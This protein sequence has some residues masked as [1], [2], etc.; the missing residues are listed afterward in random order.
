M[1]R[2]QPP[3]KDTPPAKT[4]ATDQP[5]PLAQVK[6]FVLQVG[7]SMYI[8]APELK[9][10]E[11][12]GV[13]SAKWFDD[14]K[15]KLRA[16]I[17]TMGK[18]AGL[19]GTDDDIIK[20]AFTKDA[21]RI[22]MPKDKNPRG[23]FIMT[24]AG[25]KPEFELKQTEISAQKGGNTLVINQLEVLDMTK[26]I[27][28]DMRTSNT[29]SLKASP[30]RGALGKEV[31]KFYQDVYDKAAKTKG[32]DIKRIYA[33]EKIKLLRRLETQ[34]KRIEDKGGKIPEEDKLN[35]DAYKQELKD[36][37]MKPTGKKDYTTDSVIILSM[38]G[39]GPDSRTITLPTSALEELETERQTA[40]ERMAVARTGPMPPSKESKRL[41][42]MQE[43]NPRDPN[44]LT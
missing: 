34:M 10:D 23:N 3:G 27:Y 4:P 25:M 42:D 11:I 20:E 37:N 16:G 32:A 29:D 17:L 21:L 40:G 8:N 43:A 41:K 26:L 7:V 24:N 1:Q 39:D 14:T 6:R 31:V 30:E 9:I 36:R 18:N 38:A 13:P 22:P 2:R 15:T 44:Q 35:F 33:D 19:K 5:D 12:K 28:L